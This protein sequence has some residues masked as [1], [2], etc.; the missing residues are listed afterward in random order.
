[1]IPN[2]TFYIIEIFS[3]QST[4]LSLTKVLIY[5]TE[6]E[7]NAAVDSILIG[8]SQRKDLKA[9]TTNNGQTTTFSKNNK[10]CLG[11]HTFKSKNW[12]VSELV[13][14]I[15]AL[16]DDKEEDEDGNGTEQSTTT[17]ESDKDSTATD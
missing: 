14:E 3:R 15:D 17:V 13:P 8:L 16:I 10:V 4:E 2:D 7:A 9:I 12:K 11:I 6:L 1:M 5:S